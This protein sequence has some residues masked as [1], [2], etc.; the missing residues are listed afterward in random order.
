MN[1][2]ETMTRLL[3]LRAHASSLKT[4]ALQAYD[5]WKSVSVLVDECFKT[6]SSQLGQV[7]HLRSEA[8]DL[9]LGLNQDYNDAMT[10]LAYFEMKIA[11]TGC[12]EA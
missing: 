2:D 5:N 1:H 9:Y 11:A 8:L 3:G 7:I 4:L 6:K 10:E 12:D